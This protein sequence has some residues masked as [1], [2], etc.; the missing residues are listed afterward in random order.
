MLR[1]VY[2]DVGLDSPAQWSMD[3]PSHWRG[4]SIPNWTRSERTLA[5]TVSHPLNKSSVPGLPFLLAP[6]ATSSSQERGSPN[7]LMLRIPK[8][9][10]HTTPEG[11][12]PRLP[13]RVHTFP[14][15]LRRLLWSLLLLSYGLDSTP[16]RKGFDHWYGCF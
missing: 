2:L 1:L 5:P 15:I 8:D 12:T 10:L 14:C 3:M 9:H 7:P 13:I 4:C 11:G 16:R 6:I